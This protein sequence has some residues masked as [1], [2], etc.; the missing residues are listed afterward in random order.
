MSR[1]TLEFL[2]SNKMS[3]LP[4]KREAT[5]EFVLVKDIAKP[6]SAGR[7]EYFWQNGTEVYKQELYTFSICTNQSMSSF[8][9]IIMTF[10]LSYFDNHAILKIIMGGF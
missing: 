1:R 5:Q 6:S 9:Y 10:P 7:N 3:S 2:I 8:I 4:Q